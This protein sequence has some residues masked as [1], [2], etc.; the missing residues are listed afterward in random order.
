MVNAIGA[1]RVPHQVQEE[2]ICEANIAWQIAAAI[3]LI[4]KIFTTI[5]MGRV[6]RKIEEGEIS[7]N[8][9]NISLL[10][11]YV[12]LDTVQQSYAVALTGAAIA[13]A[14]LL[15]IA[16][17]MA[18]ANFVVGIIMLIGTIALIAFSIY[19][20]VKTIQANNEALQF[21]NTIN[22]LNANQTVKA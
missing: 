9:K 19:R 4:G 13:G 5:M 12:V 14:T 20:N 17:A 11:R 6:S 2:N 15:F 7:L 3:P 18:T 1:T 10:N 16:G 22:N 8:E 21:H